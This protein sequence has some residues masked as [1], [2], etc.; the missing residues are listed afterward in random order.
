MA[1]GTRTQRLGMAL[2]AS[3][4]V[5][6]IIFASVSAEADKPAATVSSARV[7]NFA[8][9]DQHGVG[10]EL[11]YY[12]SAPALVLFVHALNDVASAQSL[13][14]IESLRADY[15]AKG[16]VFLGLNSSDRDSFDAVVTSVSNL[17]TPILK[18]EWQ[19][20]GRTLDLE[21]SADV[22]VINP[23]SWSVVYR[24]PANDKLRAGGSSQ[25]RLGHTLDALLDGKTPSPE[26]IKVK[27]SPITFPDKSRAA[28]FKKISYA[29][30]VAPILAKNCVTCHSEDGIA[31]FAMD[32]YETVKTFSPMIRESLRTRR[33][34]PFHADPRY[35]ALSDDLNM[36]RD[37]VLTVINWVEAGAERGTGD[38]P[39]A[40]LKIEVPEWP[41][42]KP[43]L[44]LDLPAF[45]VPASG[46][47]DYQDLFVDNPHKEG[48]YISAMTYKAG[49]V[50][51]VHHIIGTWKPERAQ[52]SS[53]RSVNTGGYGP[54]S[55][56]KRYPAGT[57]AY[58]PGGGHYAFQ[59]HY[60][61]TGKP[62]TD[63]TRVG[64]YFTNE[65][66]TNILRQL[67]VM[68]FTIEIPAGA[69]RHHE[70]SYVEFPEAV[71]LYG[72]RP[73]AHYRGYSTKLTLRYPDG[74]EKILHSQPRYDFAW[75][76]EYTFEQLVDVPKGSK[77]IA[78][79][80]FD[81]STDN[82]WN[83]DPTHHVTFGE[84]TMDEMLFTYVYYYI[85]GETRETPKDHVQQALQSS[86]FFSSMDDNI[87]GKLSMQELRG[88]RAAAIKKNFAALD[89]NGDGFLERSEFPAQSR[90]VSALVDG[91]LTAIDAK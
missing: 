34:P 64:L 78:D 26:T 62:E 1:I 3:S 5:A 12:K 9:T 66:P 15:E 46:I 10:H 70:R 6:A 83:P 38:D 8:L 36:S 4:A 37:E 25:V 84:Q 22:L 42:G 87:D 28:E 33:M 56:S 40:A 43:D 21:T 11:Y 69:A 86:V 14:A 57:G 30:D 19:L 72:V 79:Y 20:A 60:T 75:Q 61:T 65:P 51:T 74:A 48:K 88:A 50:S 44:I 2:L 23:K 89:K 55:E 17:K 85:D 29:K 35:S 53:L 91:D 52:G 45:E 71:K 67:G 54:G 82:K 7:D 49:A 24:G 80:I 73:H 13:Q 47:V 27:G 76:R 31:P 18:D 90:A 68:D 39:L 41:L 59:M 63:K 81:N 16:V 32:K 77:L 58:V